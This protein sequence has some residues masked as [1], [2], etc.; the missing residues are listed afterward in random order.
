MFYFTEKNIFDILERAHERC[1]GVH[2]SVG[3]N[4][5]IPKGTNKSEA[6]ETIFMHR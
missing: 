3:E 6:T 5:T 1:E 4:K 2:M